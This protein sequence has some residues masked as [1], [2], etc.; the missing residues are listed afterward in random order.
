MQMSL[1]SFYVNSCILRWERP[2]RQVG[3]GKEIRF[4]PAIGGNSTVP[5]RP[6]GGS[7]EWQDRQCWQQRW[8]KDH[9]YKNRSEEGSILL[10]ML[11]CLN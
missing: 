11:V 5:A 3:G 9:Q 6:T 10:E 2:H 1:P 7:C 8:A 4:A